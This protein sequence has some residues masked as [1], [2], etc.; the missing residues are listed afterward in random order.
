MRAAPHPGVSTVLSIET[1]PT[2]PTTKGTRRFQSIQFPDPRAERGA[3]LQG[4]K[5]HA[6][7]SPS[8]FKCHVTF[9]K[10]EG[11]WIGDGATGRVEESR[12]GPTASFSNLHRSNSHWS[13]AAQRPPPCAQAVQQLRREPAHRGRSA[14]CGEPLQDLRVARGPPCNNTPPPPLAPPPSPPRNRGGPAPAPRVLNNPRGAGR[15]G[16]A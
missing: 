6:G 5:V 11:V 14:P 7:A 12:C 8:L 3:C 13:N 15:W 4:V 16:C 10:Q 1:D 2:Y 9:C